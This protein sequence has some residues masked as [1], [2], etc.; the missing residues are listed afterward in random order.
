MAINSL[1][2]KLSLLTERFFIRLKVTY[3]VWR[4]SLSKSKPT[5]V[6]QA[7][8]VYLTLVC[9]DAEIVKQPYINPRLH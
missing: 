1:K 5:R 6:N 9:G 3:L 7:Y 2:K 8:R 4:V